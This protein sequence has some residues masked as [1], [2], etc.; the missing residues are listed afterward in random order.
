MLTLV[1]KFIGPAMII[2]GCVVGFFLV[3][4]NKEFAI[5]FACLGY[6]GIPVTVIC[7]KL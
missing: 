2:V 6:L 5:S 3:D 4:V 1:L 7:A